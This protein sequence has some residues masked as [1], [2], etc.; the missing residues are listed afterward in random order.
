[1]P[2][3]PRLTTASSARSRGKLEIRAAA[4]DATDRPH[5]VGYAALF[6]VKSD[7]GGCWT[8]E[9]APGAFSKS[10][11]RSTCSR[12]QPRHGRVVGRTGAGTLSLRE[13]DKGLAFEN[14][15]PDTT[16][17]NDLV[18]SIDRGDIP[19]CRS[20]SSRQEEWDYSVDPPHRT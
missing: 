5:R 8:E 12:S 13:D 1:M 16:D 2:R 17:G 9:F 6:G 19:E 7:V 15:L 11:R 10:L 18:V 4:G 20:A 3:H 14:E